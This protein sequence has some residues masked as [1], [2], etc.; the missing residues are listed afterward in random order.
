VPINR[1]LYCGCGIGRKKKA[2]QDNVAAPPYEK[3]VKGVEPNVTQV[4]PE[5]K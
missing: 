5:I 2:E 1:I 3:E 4:G